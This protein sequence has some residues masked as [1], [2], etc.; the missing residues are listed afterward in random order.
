MSYEFDKYK[1]TTNSVKNK[2]DEYG[3]AIIPNL[4][5]DEECDNMNNGILNFFEHISQNWKNPFSP[6]KREDVK[7]WEN[8]YYLNPILF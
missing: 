7:S 3:V 4:L 1:C 6:I 8:I 2:L 5:N